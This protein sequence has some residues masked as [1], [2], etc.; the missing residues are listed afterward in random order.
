MAK[1][2]WLKIVLKAKKVSRFY[3]TEEEGT[4]KKVLAMRVFYTVVSMAFFR[5]DSI[6][7]YIE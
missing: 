1:N 4:T 7:Q 6:S 5:I 2:P 3:F